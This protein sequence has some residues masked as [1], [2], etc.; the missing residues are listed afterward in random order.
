MKQGL[1]AE[2]AKVISVEP[3]NKESTSEKRLEMVRSET[4][5]HD[6]QPK[7]GA[8]E[9]ERGSIVSMPTKTTFSHV[10]ELPKKQF[11][12]PPHDETDG[13]CERSD[14]TSK[15]STSGIEK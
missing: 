4:T 1:P 8:K 15:P 14:L 11:R 6:G 5:T 13:V 10:T 12:S 7:K 3:V 9:A 2:E